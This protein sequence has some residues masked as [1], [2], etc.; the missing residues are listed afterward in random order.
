MENVDSSQWH[1]VCITR[2]SSS[3]NTH[4][5]WHGDELISGSKFLLPGKTI[6]KGGI[7]QLAGL[8]RRDFN[9]LSTRITTN[10]PVRISQVNV[11]NRVLTN[12]ETAALATRQNCDGASGN[13]LD[14]QDFRT[15]LTLSKFIESDPSECSRAS[16]RELMF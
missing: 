14:W 11:W 12:D 13:V 9:E 15:G 1:T 3:G 4:L 2:E 8:A 16:S 5:F 10:L 7:I 6:K